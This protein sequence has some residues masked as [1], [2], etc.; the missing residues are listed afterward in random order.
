[1]VRI[2]STKKRKG[3]RFLSIPIILVL[4]GFVL[5]SLSLSQLRT[6]Q[7]SHVSNTSLRDSS[8]RGSRPVS[9]G[10]K[11]PPVTAQ[12]GDNVL[13]NTPTIAYAVSVT[14]CGSDPITEGGAVLQ[15]SIHRA[16]VHGTLKGKYDYKLFAI[17]HPDAAACAKPLA[18]LGYELLEREVM[19]NVDD[20][21]GDFLRSKIRTNGCCGEKEL[22][23]LE[24]YRL[25]DYPIVVHLDLDVLVLKPLDDLFD[26]M[27]E[28]TSSV[29]NQ[30]TFLMPNQN[31]PDR[32]NAFYTYDYNMVGPRVE[33]KPV[34]GGFFVT[35]PD[36]DVYEEYRAIV[37]KGDF[38]QGSGWGGKVGPFHGS[39]TFQGI[40]P[41]YYNVLHPGQGVELNR[42]VYN[43]MCDNP[44][45]GRTVNDVVS[46]QCRTNTEEC[47]DCRER[48]IEDVVTTHFTLCQKPWWCLPHSQN[49]IQHRLCRKLTQEWYKIRSELEQS[50][51]RS[52]QGT[53]EFE[54]DIFFGYCKKNGKDGYIPIAQPYGGPED[55]QA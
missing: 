26:L 24:A 52:G 51:H 50:W 37:K 10:N 38:R 15:H 22:I 20:I 36:M 35:R 25:T 46:G 6:I 7:E 13:K 28:G 32:I 45:T 48:N 4:T 8:T 16:S 39:M 49:A 40:V 43:Q 1:M 23:K 14:G 17:Y 2:S 42:C 54:K 29:S 31:I 5:V 33:Y 21:E 44:R 34:Q 55:G 41:Y 27:L 18:A 53:G 30:E 11:P 12:A 47:E 3:Y 9:V 19:V